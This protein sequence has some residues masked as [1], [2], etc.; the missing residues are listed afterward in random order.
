M[1]A[2]ATVPLAG[3]LMGFLYYNFNPASIFLGDCGSLFLG[4]ILGCLGVI[5][6]QKAV[7]LLGLTAPLMALAVPVLDVGLSIVRRYLRRQ[8]LFTADRGHIHHRLL[9]MGLR[10]R[11]VAIVLYGAGGLAATFS[12][13]QTLTYRRFGGLMVVLFCTITWVGVQRLHYVELDILRRMLMGGE[14][15]RILSS[16]IRLQLLEDSL[17]KAKTPD[18]CWLL[19]RDACH[20]FGFNRVALHY[21]GKQYDGRFREGGNL[22]AWNARLPLSNSDYID[23]SAPFQSTQSGAVE[24]VLGVLR[25]QMQSKIIPPDVGTGNDGRTGDGNLPDLV[26]AR[27]A[28]VD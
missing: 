15:R 3:G 10:P 21:G 8:P 1:L 20:E 16:R 2:I 27:A 23:I 6:S 18:E 26:E 7:T 22:E 13:L 5:W 24:L 12:L 19:I 17:R 4:F 9:A 14:F 25:A 11:D 28:G